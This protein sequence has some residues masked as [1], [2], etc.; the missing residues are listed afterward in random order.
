MYEPETSG[1]AEMING[2]LKDIA[3]QVVS[4]IKSQGL[5]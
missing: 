4:I 5:V 1:H 3:D 2:N